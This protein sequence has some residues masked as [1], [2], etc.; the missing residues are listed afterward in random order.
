MQA[1]LALARE[2]VSVGEV[3][4]GALVVHDGLVIGASGNRTVSD[5]NPT[6]HFALMAIREAA[7]ALGRWRLNGC[8]LYVTLEPCSM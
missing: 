6:A 4:V 7:A 3:P 1:A 8:T 2:G 5:M